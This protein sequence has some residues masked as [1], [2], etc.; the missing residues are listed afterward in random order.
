MNRKT[1]ITFLVLVLLALA[2]VPAA[3]QGAYGIAKVG[4]Y[5]H[6]STGAPLFRAGAHPD[7]DFSIDL[8]TAPNPET[9][10]QTVD[11]NAKDIDLT[12]PPGL[13]GNPSVTPKCTHGELV[14]LLYLADCDP[15]TQ[16]GIA[17]VTNYAR[18]SSAETPVPIYNV[19]PQKGVAG[20]FAFNLSGD[21]VYLDSGVTDEGEYRL[22]TDVSRISQGL[23]IGATSIDLWADPASP[24]HDYERAAKGTPAPPPPREEIV[25][26]YDSEGNLVYERVQVPVP[27][28]SSARQ[29][30]LMTNPTSCSG[31]PLSF[32]AKTDSWLAPGVFSSGSYS[33]DLDGNPITITDCDAVPFEASLEAQPTSQQAESP[34]GL[35]VDLHLPQSQ[36]PG[37][38]ASAA[39]REAVV[40]LPQGMAIDPASAGGLGSCSPAQ[41]GLGN[42][43]APSCPASARI[44]TLKIVTPLLEAP[45]EG[46]VYLAQQG[47]NKFG[48]LLALYLVVDDAQTGTVLK[49][50]GKVAADPTSGRLTA[51]FAE[52]PQ[53]PFEE[54]KLAFFGGPRAALQNP[55]ACGTYSTRG[56]FSPWSGGAPIV[57]TDSFAITSGPEGSACPS[58]GFDPKL[59]AGTANP[60][61]G[62]YSPFE[63]KITRPD[64]SGVLSGVSVKLPKGLLAK[65]AGVPYCPDAALAAV[66]TAEGTGAAQLASPSCP[67]ASR[68]GTVAV[69]AGAGPSPFWAKT[70]SAYLAGPYKGAP[71]SLA[72]VTP[73]LAGPFDLGNV[74]V[75]VALDVD[76]T[77]AQVSA[78]ADPLPTILDGIP[79]SLREVQVS[80]DRENFTLNPTSCAPAK[81][82]SV[83][84]ALGGATATPSAPFAASGC[85]GLR[86]APKL[87]LKLAGGTSRGAFPQLTATLKA[88]PG[89]AN[90]ARVAVAL[91]HSEFLEQGHIGTVCTRVEFAAEKCPAKSIYGY[92][93]AKTPLLAKPLRGPV[94]LRSSSNKL[95]DLVAA[96]RGQIEIDLDGRIDSKDRGIR[97]T[98]A[99]IPDAPISSFTLRL[100]GGAK[101]LLVNS[102]QTCGSKT[103]AQ[104]SMLAQNG[105]RYIR[106]DALST[107]KCT[108]PMG[109]G[110]P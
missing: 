73:A 11:G 78:V 83:L 28:P 77:T 47:Q 34:T 30:A 64:G 66:P 92:A 90:L 98:F 51:S 33:S 52:A 103:K 110:R 48:S 97:T 32:A 37:G 22:S 84:S 50:P 89:Q 14:E 17:T 80:L 54:L 38:T 31:A 40:T 60:A 46:G 4:G 36:L 105:D 10:F 107:R 25:E 7:F 87:S 44:G 94:Y 39:L 5:L 8:N 85:G 18:E 6:D 67:A 74:V 55:P 59:E 65:L 102:T 58:G 61:A 49:I 70:G 12:L 24:S 81:V 29:A 109:G 9:G 88:R 56:E 101:S 75:R 13:I 45:L 20:Q 82:T 99:T 2:A 76:P 95:P 108:L 86:F 1:T 35:T 41:I 23:A 27:V 42:D 19:V 26:T 57:A 3:A 68:V 63:L 21:V 106:A 79:L 53:L 16:V 62:R 104:V 15:S 71:L 69:A 91:P 93:E 72:L 96:L 43:A 100:K